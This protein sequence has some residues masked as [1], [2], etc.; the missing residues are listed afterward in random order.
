MITDRPFG[1][2]PSELCEAFADYFDCDCVY[3][4]VMQDPR[5]I[6]DAFH[7]AVADS[8]GNGM[9]PVLVAV[10]DNL[11]EAIALNVSGDECDTLSELDK[12]AIAGYRKTLIAEADRQTAERFF[13]EAMDAYGLDPCGEIA[14]GEALR[15]P[16]LCADY[17]ET[18]L[19]R[20]PV[21]APWQVA[22]WLPM[23]NWNDCPPPPVMIA[24]TKKWQEDSGAVICHVTGDSI[25]YRVPHP[26][27]NETSVRT[28]AEEHELFCPYCLENTPS[29]TRGA[30]MDSLTQSTVWHFWWD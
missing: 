9:I 22:A 19:V 13:H 15:E 14:D 23:G 26:L 11:A 1:G 16:E 8:E 6:L 20:I 10:D 2:E 21:I 3:F 5:P 24:V 12:E 4:P 27:K 17:C 30:W 7:K 28:L 29:C 25:D 18:L